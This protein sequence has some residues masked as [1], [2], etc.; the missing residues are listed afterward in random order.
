MEAI[1]LF[2]LILWVAHQQDQINALKLKLR[3]PVPSVH[4]DIVE[5]A[6]ARR[7]KIAVP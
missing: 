1:L 3:D 6:R 2:G 4:P 7:A 5:A